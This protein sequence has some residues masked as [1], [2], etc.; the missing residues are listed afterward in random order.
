VAMFLLILALTTYRDVRYIWVIVPQTIFWSNVHGGYIYVFITL[1]PFIV[2][3]LLTSL[4]RDRFVSIGKRGILH[5]LGA[6]VA[7]FVASIVLNPYHVTNFTHTFVISVSKDAELWRNVAEWFSPFDKKVNFGQVTP[8]FIMCGMSGLI[9]LAWL[10][11]IPLKPKLTQKA[12]R[13]LKP[14]DI[15]YSWPKVDLALLVVWFLTIYMAVKSRRFIPLAAIA[16]CPMMAVMLDQTIRMLFARRRFKEHNQLVVP[17]MSDRLVRAF[18][19]SMAGVTL[20]FAVAFGWMLKKEYMDANPHYLRSDTLFVRMTTSYDKPVGAIEFLRQNLR[21]GRIFHPWTEGAYVSWGQDPDPVTGKTPI[22]VFIDG[23]AQAAYPPDKFLRYMDLSVGGPSGRMLRGGGELSALQVKE[24]AQWL[25]TEFKKYRVSVV[26]T[27]MRKFEAVCLLAT[28]ANWRPAYVDERFMLLVDTDYPECKKLYEDLSQDRVKFPDDFSRELTHAYISVRVN[29][30]KWREIGLNRAAKALSLRPCSVAAQQ[31]LL[32][33]RDPSL[34]G[35][36]GTVCQEFL[37]DFVKN[38]K[39]YDQENGFG[40]RA[41]AAEVL[42]RG[43][44][45]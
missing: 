6:M 36:V 45:R 27:S 24:I 40:L 44:A 10:A 21:T 30:G 39:K 33:G 3:H 28:R 13:K 7:A 42:R 25:D 31:V 34:S 37:A 2:I 26:L 8:F 35:R 14:E 11:A 4:W 12:I 9:F 17:P 22:P 23:R 38:R 32:A 20:V 1:I 29:D 18:T 16:A 41:E 43:V 19:F 15:S 5:V